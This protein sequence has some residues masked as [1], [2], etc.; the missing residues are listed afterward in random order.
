METFKTVSIREKNY[1][2]VDNFAYT[3]NISKAEALNR[4]IN[5][6]RDNERIKELDKMKKKL[7]EV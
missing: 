6:Y 3:H 7:K 2:F 4:I 5:F 1:E